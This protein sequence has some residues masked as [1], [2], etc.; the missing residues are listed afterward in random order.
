VSGIL[1]EDVK[2]FFAVV[3]GGRVKPDYIRVIDAGQNAHFVDGT[4]SLV[5]VHSK[6]TYLSYNYFIFLTAND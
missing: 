6:T 5:L 1:H 4:G 3:E 2:F